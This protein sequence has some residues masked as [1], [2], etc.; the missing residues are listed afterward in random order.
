M[1]TILQEAPRSC[2]KAHYLLHGLGHSPN[3]GVRADRLESGVRWGR[4]EEEGGESQGGK[5]EIICGSCASQIED[6]KDI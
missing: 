6:E 4:G 5:G 2:T 1:N 3:S